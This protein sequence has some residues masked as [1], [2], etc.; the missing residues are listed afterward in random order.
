MTTERQTATALYL[1]DK[2][3]LKE[4]KRKETREKERKKEIKKKER[5]IDL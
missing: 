3:F 5:R 2:V 4:N 1:I